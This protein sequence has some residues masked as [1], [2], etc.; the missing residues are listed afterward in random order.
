MKQFQPDVQGA[1]S[2][3]QTVGPSAQRAAAP[4]PYRPP[5]Q[6]QR[7]ATLI[8]AGAPPVYRPAVQRAPAPASYRPP[9]QVQR[10]A[11]LIAAGAP[12]VYRPAV[13][14]APAP[15]PYR[16]PGQ[17]QRRVT[18]IVTGAPPVYRPAVQRAPAPA[19]YR[20]P[21]QVQRRATSIQRR[22]AIVRKPL[23]GGPPNDL[24]MP[25][26]VNRSVL[27]RMKLGDSPLAKQ[28]EYKYSERQDIVWAIV[29]FSKEIHLSFYPHGPGAEE[30]KSKI[31]GIISDWAQEYGEWSARNREWFKLWMLNNLP[32]DQF[33]VTI[34]GKHFH[35]SE[36]GDA[37]GEDAAGN[38]EI[39]HE[40]RETAWKYSGYALN[41]Q[42][43]QLPNFGTRD[44]HMYRTTMHQSS[45]S[46]YSGIE[47]EGTFR[48]PSEKWPNMKFSKEKQ[49]FIF[50]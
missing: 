48:L 2:T 12:P 27:Q 14:R 36:T 13:Q 10:R 32:Y 24:A 37:L 20:P 7:R 38:G 47:G 4:A 17:V 33:H 43:R 5:D 25:P 42:E 45:L 6:V 49:E 21:G 22:G 44:S 23:I 9:D 28:A 11:T 30:Y 35:F 40:E 15:A 41:G 19:P 31:L 16:P 8:G 29:D 26:T 46:L 1:R 34:N 50:K 18:S 3:P 39:T